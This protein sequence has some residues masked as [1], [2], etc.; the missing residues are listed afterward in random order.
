MSSSFVAGPRL[1]AESR[2]SSSSTTLTATPLYVE[3]AG[4]LRAWYSSRRTCALSPC[5]AA[6]EARL[7][8][9]P[10]CTRRVLR[11]ASMPLI[12]LFTII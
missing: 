9:A 5:T 10:G 6:G 8:A 4:V 1:M 7:C 11:S 12:K 2:L 3:A